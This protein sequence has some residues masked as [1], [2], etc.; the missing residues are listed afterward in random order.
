MKLLTGSKVESSNIVWNSKGEVKMYS[1]Q[2]DGITKVMLQVKQ[3]I[4]VASKVESDSVILAELQRKMKRMV[5]GEIRRSEAN[6]PKADVSILRF[7]GE[8]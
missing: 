7:E 3:P 2:V 6:N 4:P 1:K 8:L 5:E